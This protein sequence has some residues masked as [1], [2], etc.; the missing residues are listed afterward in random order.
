MFSARKALIP[1]LF[2]AQVVTLSLAGILPAGS[3]L[4]R[5]DDPWKVEHK[6]IGKPRGLDPMDA[7]K[8]KDVSGIACATTS[9]FPRIC[10]IVDDETQGA[11][12]VILKKD[13]LIAGDFIRLIH[14]TYVKDHSKK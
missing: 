2:L 4:A 6:L 13:K 11:Q 1:R 8:S 10:L 3:A 9:G 14:T 12:I 5:G 7:D